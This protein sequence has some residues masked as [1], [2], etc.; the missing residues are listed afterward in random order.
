MIDPAATAASAAG[1]RPRLSAFDGAVR[2]SPTRP[3][4]GGSPSHGGHEL[5]HGVEPRP[6]LTRSVRVGTDSG[7]VEQKRAPKGRTALT[8]STHI[9]VSVAAAR[10]SS[11]RSQQS[12]F[13]G[14]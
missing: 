6:A 13:G 14:L 1:A 8:S 3:T 4:T 5:V 11:A 12:R 9:R 10:E 7:A 2:D